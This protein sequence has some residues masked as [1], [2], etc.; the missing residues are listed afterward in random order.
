MSE[1]ISYDPLR[2]CLYFFFLDKECGC[3]P[4]KI[5]LLKSTIGFLHRYNIKHLRA[6]TDNSYMGVLQIMKIVHPNK[7]AFG[8]SEANC[9]RATKSPSLV[10]KFYCHCL[11]KYVAL[12]EKLYLFM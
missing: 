1:E 10:F 6:T 12:C 7:T 2:M 9:Y 8:Y 3:M 4:L 5:P 11:S